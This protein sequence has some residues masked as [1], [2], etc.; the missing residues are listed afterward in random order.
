MLL[1]VYF[2][3]FLFSF[4]P[5]YCSNS[6]VPFLP[7]IHNPLQGFP[8]RP[9]HRAWW[10]VLLPTKE[11]GTN[12]LTRRN[13]CEVGSSLRLILPF[14]RR[15]SRGLHSKFLFI[16]AWTVNTTFIQKHECVHVQH[17]LK[18]FLIMCANCSSNMCLFLVSSHRQTAKKEKKR[19]E[20]L[21]F[22]N[23]HQSRVKVTLPSSTARAL[24]SSFL[25]LFGPPLAHS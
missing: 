3:S 12:G 18:A 19:E 20:E 25:L 2:W 11:G 7:N 5:T 21:L 8:P 13:E 9:P 22:C 15:E 17:S 4:H 16:S 10:C 23:Q 24:F 14:F 1:Y 6:K